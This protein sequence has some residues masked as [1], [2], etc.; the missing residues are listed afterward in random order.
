MREVNFLPAW[1]PS[2]RRQRASLTAQTW[3][4]AGLVVAGLVTLAAVHAHSTEAAAALQ[5]TRHRAIQATQN[6]QKLD[7]TLVLQQQLVAKQK[8]LTDVGLP[9]EVARVVGELAQA[10]PRE[11]C[12]DSIEIR[13]DEQTRAPSIA[14]RAKAGANVSPTVTRRLQVRLTGLAPT[15]DAVT[16]MW[17]KLL[18]QPFVDDARLANSTDHEDSGHLMRAFEIT[19][20]I[21]MDV[22]PE[23]AR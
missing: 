18:Q 3:V 5:Q 23:V 20:S 6:V 12:F 2:L 19:L 17:S 14:D 1:Y 4:T 13:T 22:T 11:V 15:E 8:V 7:E 10:A 9:V 16:M 21:P